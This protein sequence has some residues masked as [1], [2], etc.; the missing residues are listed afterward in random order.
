MIISPSGNRRKME[1]QNYL[2][3]EPISFPLVDKAVKKVADTLNFDENTLP[4]DNKF[5]ADQE[6][7]TDDYS[8]VG[9]AMNE[10]ITLPAANTQ[11]RAVIT[12]VEK[13]IGPTQEQIGQNILDLMLEKGLI[14]AGNF[15]LK[16]FE[17]SSGLHLIILPQEGPIVSNK[18]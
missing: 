16:Q 13:D 17:I 5:Q 7:K 4:T 15:A 6:P 8:G 10:G 9:Q 2:A 3:D 12:S 1:T 18:K 14:K 11:N